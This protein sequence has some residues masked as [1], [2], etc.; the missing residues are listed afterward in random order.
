[1]RIGWESSWGASQ[2]CIPDA[3]LDDYTFD[4]NLDNCISDANLDNY[5]PEANL[6]VENII[7]TQTST[8]IFQ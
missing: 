6:E 4:A 7:L 2:S 3:N 1:M 5:I 8:I